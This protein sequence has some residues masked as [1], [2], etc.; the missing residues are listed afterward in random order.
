MMPRVHGDV[1][2]RVRSTI[3]PG[4]RSAV[5]PGHLRLMADV[6]RAWEQHLLVE[7]FAL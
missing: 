2:A 6:R 4:G 7:I 1:D 5:H 3:H